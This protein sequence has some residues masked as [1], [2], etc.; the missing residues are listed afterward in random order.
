MSELVARVRN[1]LNTA[2]KPQDKARTLLLS[3]TLAEIKNR[4]IELMRDLTDEDAMEVLQ[5]GIKKRRESVELYEKAGRKELADKESAEITMLEAYLPARV[6]DTEI[7]E[8]VSAVI[9]GGATAIGAVMGAVIPKF[10]GRADGSR[11]NAI[12]REELA[13]RA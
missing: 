9:S 2:R 13:K 10:K 7:R 6:S 5:K 4:R 12:A 11:I 3:T 8:A 1:D